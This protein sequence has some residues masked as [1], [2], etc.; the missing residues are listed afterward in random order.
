MVRGHSRS[1]AASRTQTSPLWTS[2]GRCAVRMKNHAA[3]VAAAWRVA[4]MVSTRGKCDSEIPEDKIAFLHAPRITVIS[5]RTYYVSA[6][7]L[8]RTK[9]N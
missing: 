4:G 8:L 9:R 6:G 7:R 1:S 2:S 3:Y 5:L